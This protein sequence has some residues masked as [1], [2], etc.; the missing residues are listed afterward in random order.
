MSVLS[1]VQIDP[2]REA[3][4]RWATLHERRLGLKPSSAA[5]DAGYAWH[6]LLAAAFGDQA[7]RPFVDR[8]V[9]RSNLVLGYTSVDPGQL[10]TNPELDALALRA[11][12]IERLKMTVMPDG[13]DAGQVLGFE[14]RSRP[15]VRTRRYARTG[16]IDEM[17]AAVHAAIE[18]SEVEREQAYAKWLEQELGRDGACK[19]ERVRMASFRRTRILRRNQG[20]DRTPKLIEGPEAWLV[21]RLVIE[22]PTAFQNLIR[23]GLGRHRAFGFGCLIVGR[24]GVLD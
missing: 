3:F 8:Q 2:D 18:N 13:W 7:P 9:L 24:P 20:K 15:I 17:D 23:R 19:L 16:K 21:G 4:A 12:A 11:L 22:Q 1:L 14:V 10:Q 5:P 6:A